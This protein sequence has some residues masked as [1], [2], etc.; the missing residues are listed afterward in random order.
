MAQA[1]VNLPYFVFV[2]SLIFSLI[3]EKKLL[4]EN[5]QFDVIITANPRGL[6]YTKLPHC[7]VVLI[8]Q[9]GNHNYRWARLMFD[10]SSPYW[11]EL[12]D[13]LFAI[14]RLMYVWHKWWVLD[15]V[16]VCS[17]CWCWDRCEPPLSFWQK[18][19]Y[20]ITQFLVM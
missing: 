6:V 17:R 2:F 7:D 18:T 11:D 12:L 15:L 19:S 4:F 9:I 14:W 20:R 10:K 13:E 5:K 3:C 8:T 16:S 1:L